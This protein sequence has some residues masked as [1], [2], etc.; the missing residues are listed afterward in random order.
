MEKIRK[1]GNISYVNR[2]DGAAITAWRCPGTAVHFPE[3]IDGLPVTEIGAA[4]FG[5]DAMNIESIEVPGCVRKID[6]GA[7]SDCLSLKS[8]TLHEGLRSLGRNFVLFS[9]LTALTI[10]ASV[11]EIEE[12][13]DL[14]G[15]ALTIAAGN[16]IY[17][18]DGYAHY[19]GNQLAAVISD[20]EREEYTVREGTAALMPR[21]FCGHTHLRTLTLPSG[22]TEIGDCA[23]D[24]GTDKIGSGFAEIRLAGKKTTGTDLVV[25]LADSRAFLLKKTTGTEK[26]VLLRSLGGTRDLRLPEEVTEVGPRALR[27]SPVVTL[28]IPK[29]VTKVGAEALKACT[30]ISTIVL[31]GDGAAIYVPPLEFRKEEITSLLGDAA[32]HAGTVFDYESY[33][34]IAGSYP[35]PEYRLKMALCRF[36]APVHLT[37]EARTRYHDYIAKNILAVLGIIA[38]QEDTVSLLKLMK[39]GFF[40]QE[41]IGDAVE[42]LS[43]CGHPLITEMMLEYQFKNYGSQ[44]SDLEL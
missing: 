13:S 31:E 42:F 28:R 11:E 16:R 36:D 1:N 26:V 8:L 4:V 41:G 40:P 24:N 19:A 25:F 22:L 9:S 43:T 17:S 37:A 44:E 39:Y 34:R 35:Y 10:P 5:E 38:E 30:A 18:T 7:F 15:M 20:D 29:S 12:P 21:V 27:A 3:R 14:A 6:G 33:D 2:A 32:S 23:L